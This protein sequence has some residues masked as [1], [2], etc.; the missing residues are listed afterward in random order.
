ML[1]G[2]LAGLVLFDL[3]DRVRVPAIAPN[4]IAA[5][6]GILAIVGSFAVSAS[7]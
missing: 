1:G 3:R 6:I 5:A 2:A 7:A 4:L